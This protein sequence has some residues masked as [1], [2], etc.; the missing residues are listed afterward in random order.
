MSDEGYTSNEDFEKGIEIFQRSRESG[1]NSLDGEEKDEF[2][3]QTRW[4][5]DIGR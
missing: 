4:V 2:E 3:R 1:L 5:L